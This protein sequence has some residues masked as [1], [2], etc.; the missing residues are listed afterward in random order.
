MIDIKDLTLQQRSLLLE[1][2]DGRIEANNEYI[3]EMETG[4]EPSQALEEIREE[5]D[6]LKELRSLFDAR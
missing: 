5:N 3:I 1:M 2:I 6:S 4:R